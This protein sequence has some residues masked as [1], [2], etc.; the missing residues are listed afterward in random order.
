MIVPMVVPHR[1]DHRA[2]DPQRLIGAYAQQINRL[3]ADLQQRSTVVVG[4]FMD[5]QVAR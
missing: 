5:I 4:V 1:T 2:V 3:A